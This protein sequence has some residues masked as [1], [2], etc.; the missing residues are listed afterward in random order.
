M[1]ISKIGLIFFTFMGFVAG[2][3]LRCIIDKIKQD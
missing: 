2:Y 1:I 3:L